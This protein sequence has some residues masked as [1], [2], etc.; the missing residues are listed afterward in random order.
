MIDSVKDVEPL[1][2]GIRDGLYDDIVDSA[3]WCRCHIFLCVVLIHKNGAPNGEALVPIT[4]VVEELDQLR[5]VK[6]ELLGDLACPLLNDL[7][8]CHILRAV[9]P[10]LVVKGEL[11][12]VHK[13]ARVGSELAVVPEE[14]NE[15]VYH[16]HSIVPWKR[17]EA[18]GNADLIHDLGICHIPGHVQPI[19]QDLVMIFA[20][21]AE[22]IVSQLEIDAHLVC[23][24]LKS[25]ST[26]WDW[27]IILPC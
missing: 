2:G 26:A 12:I 8:L 13:L 9:D 10:L 25:G 19:H 18:E 6:I 15:H 27:A 17:H 21:W 5:L 24:N 11:H 7:I 16:P 22:Q 20:V 3:L 23:T 4:N 1:I 14:G